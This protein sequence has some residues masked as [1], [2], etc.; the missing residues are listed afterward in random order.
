MFS[1]QQN[2]LQI[3]LSNPGEVLQAADFVAAGAP[4]CSIR[5]RLHLAV[6]R[7]QLQCVGR[8]LF[9]AVG[10]RAAAGVR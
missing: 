7:G 3:A 5:I 10:V 2:V 9:A 8:G 4:A 6:K 1:N